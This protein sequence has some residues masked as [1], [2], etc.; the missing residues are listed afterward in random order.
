MTRFEVSTRGRAEEHGLHAEPD[1]VQEPVVGERADELAAADEPH[2]LLARRVDQGL[3]HRAH[4]ALHEPDVHV[5]EDW[6]L[7]VREDLS[8]IHI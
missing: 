2:V 6:E 8:L 1:L 4:V 3:V 7:P 5:R